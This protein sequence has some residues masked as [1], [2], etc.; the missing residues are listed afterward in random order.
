MSRSDFLLACLLLCLQTACGEGADGDDPV[1]PLRLLTA[2]VGNPATSDPRYALRVSYQAYEDHVAS[3]IQ[4][5]APDIAFLQEVLP[6][7]T[8]EAFQ[9]T[10]PTR[11]CFEASAR[12]PAARRLLGP[13]YTIVCD[14][15]LHVECIGVRTSFGSIDGVDR[16]AFV[17]GGAATPALPL[18]PC[19]YFEGTCDNDHCDAEA[20]TSAV[21]VTTAKGPMRL[22]HVHPNAAG[23]NKDGLYLGEPCRYLQLQQV[24]AGKAPLVGEGKPVLVAGDFNMD[25]EA[26]ASDREKELWNEH[27]GEGKRFADIGP[28]RNEGGTAYA[29]AKIFAI[30]RVIGDG[31]SGGCSIHTKNAVEDDPAVVATLDDGFDFAQLPGGVGAEERMDHASLSCDIEA[32]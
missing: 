15:R 5:L 16:G 27:V 6:P 28:P 9:E 13:D 18:D 30:D 24:F 11:T 29:T 7:Q 32:D 17:L 12:P 25:P 19:T 1:P 31:F 23:T 3:K 26:F 22:V 21:D 4:A 10:D 8:C 2:N 14:A 20:T